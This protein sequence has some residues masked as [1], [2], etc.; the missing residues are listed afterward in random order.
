MLPRRWTVSPCAASDSSL[1]PAAAAASASTGLVRRLGM[2]SLHLVHL[3]LL[4]AD[5]LTLAP[6]HTSPPSFV[7]CGRT[8]AR[9]EVVGVVVSRDRREKFLRFL[10]DDGTGCVPCVLWL[11]HR[12]MN[13]NS[14]SGA[15]D[16][17]PTGEMALKM[18]EVVR[19]G[20]LLRACLEDLMPCTVFL[21]VVTVE[22]SSSN[23]IQGLTHFT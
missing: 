8:V 13:A 9:A 7:R 3:K 1:P 23:A 10:V 19:L 21:S 5:L 14:S 20:T 15:L 2:D 18:S 17:D 4:A 16:S 6:R 12:Y 11:N 22:P